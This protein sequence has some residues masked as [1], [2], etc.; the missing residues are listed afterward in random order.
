MRPSCEKLGRIGRGTPDSTPSYTPV[1]FSR[2]Y[3]QNSKTPKSFAIRLIG[4]SFRRAAGMTSSLNARGIA[5]GT[6]SVLP[7][8]PKY[9]QRW[10][11]PTDNSPMGWPRQ[12]KKCSRQTDGDE[13]RRGPPGGAETVGAFTI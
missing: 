10:S 12:L 8:E 4:A 7:C 5:F 2:R 1:I 6:V 11:Q 9:S 13:R 3:W